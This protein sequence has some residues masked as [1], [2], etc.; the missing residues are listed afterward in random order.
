ME[1]PTRIS[2]ISTQMKMVTSFGF[3]VIALAQ[4]TAKNASFPT[5]FPFSGLKPC[6]AG[7]D[8]DGLILVWL[9][10]WVGFRYQDEPK[11]SLVRFFNCQAQPSPNSSWTEL[12]LLSL[13]Q[14][15]KG[16]WH[17]GKPSQIW[18]SQ[19]QKILERIFFSNPDFKI[20][21]PP[22]FSGSNI[23]YD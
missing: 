8:K 2:W 12:A 18:N 21:L 13:Y 5:L 20:Y 19:N 3:I 14:P 1:F 7:K 11:F 10:F 16:G 4:L 23:F 22:W 6:F 15:D 9:T 17:L